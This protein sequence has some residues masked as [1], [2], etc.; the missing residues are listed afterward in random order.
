VTDIQ[1]GRNLW[2]SCVLAWAIAAMMAVP[3]GLALEAGIPPDELQAV[4]F[5]LS[6]LR[7]PDAAQLAQALGVERVS[8]EPARDSPVNCLQDLGDLD[9]DGVPEYAL[10]WSRA[11]LPA[12]AAAAE[13]AKLAWALFLLN[14]DG[15]RWRALPLMG[16]FEPF[17]VQ[18]LPAVTMDE[19][20]ISVTVFEGSSRVPF[21]VIFRFRAH[22]LAQEWDGR[23]DENR[24]EGFDQGELTFSGAGGALQMIA[25]GRADPGFLVFPRTGPRGFDARTVY[26]WENNAFIPVKTAYTENRDYALYRFIVTLHVHDFKTAYG[27]IDPARFL[28]TR[29]PTL[30]AFRKRM[31]EQ[32]PEFLDDRIFRA[33]DSGAGDD[34]FVL[35]L[36]DKVYVY[37]PSF[38]AGSRLLL[39]GLER[40]ERK[41][42]D[43]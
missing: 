11:Q 3:A 42:E 38:S 10:E 22:S 32:F 23:S 30:A 29:K 24:Y 18:V 2:V 35:K 6:V 25:T 5:R 33:Q 15:G 20:L 1:E 28:K 12:T 4:Q 7:S 27:L 14:W 41:P 37:T 40:Q 26:N 13:G 9:G 34:S 36:P 17:V 16:G 19:R 39:T 31:E 21:P 43:E 8:K